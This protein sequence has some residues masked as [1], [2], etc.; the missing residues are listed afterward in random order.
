MSDPKVASGLG[1]WKLS[2]LAGIVGVLI[3]ALGVSLY[4]NRSSTWTQ[5]TVANKNL[6]RS[7]CCGS[8]SNCNTPSVLQFD[9]DR[10]VP[11]E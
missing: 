11:I 7:D 6:K 10:A 4:F 9:P 3:G 8:P 5:C 2:L 1:G